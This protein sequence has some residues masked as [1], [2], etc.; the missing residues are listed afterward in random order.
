MDRLN[1]N[2]S[3]TLIGNA[4][5]RPIYSHTAQGVRYF[6]FP[7]TVT[8]LSGSDD[9]LNICC[10]EEKLDED[11]SETTDMLKVVGELRSHN[12]RSG[13]GNKLLIFVYA[14]EI[15]FV[16]GEPEN[17]VFIS[18]ALCKPPSL[19]VTPLGREI[20]DLLLAVNRPL[21]R[22]DYLPCI[23]WGRSAREASGF[24]VGQRVE[25]DGRIQSRNYIK[26]ID[27]V[28]YTK[29]AFEVSAMEI[30]GI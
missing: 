14:H 16:S 29:T 22:S 8:R 9:T 19:R 1:A 3:V 20:C 26:I 27:G 13:V 15:S 10:R 24:T 25:L 21:G 18:G 6:S 7:L 28:Q 23:C 30:R 11:F 5:G 17:K 12:N 2:N 4:A